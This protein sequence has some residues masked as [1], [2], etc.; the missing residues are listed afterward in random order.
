VGRLAPEV[1]QEFCAA[2]VAGGLSDYTAFAC[3]GR[4]DADAQLWLDLPE[5]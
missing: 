2:V 3:D 1:A 5:D 4:I